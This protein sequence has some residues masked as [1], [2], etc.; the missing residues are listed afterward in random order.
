MDTMWNFVK[1]NLNTEIPSFE[2]NEFDL[3]YEIAIVKDTEDD[4][5]AILTEGINEGAFVISL[6]IYKTYQQ[7][8]LV[9]PDWIQNTKFQFRTERQSFEMENQSQKCYRPFQR[10]NPNA[11][12]ISLDMY[13]TYQQNQLVTPDWIQKHKIPVSYRKAKL[14]NGKSVTKVLPIIPKN[15]LNRKET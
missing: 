5:F 6:G 2:K 11:F 7:N 4:D 12:V 9:T 13:K 1:N 10:P 15:I 3:E 14:R 8:Q